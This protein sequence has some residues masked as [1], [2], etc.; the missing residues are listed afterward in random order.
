MKKPGLLAGI[1]IGAVLLLPVMAVSYL[2]TTLAGFTF[3][4]FALFDWIGR[5]LP[6]GLITS[7]IDSMVATVNAINPG[8][9]SDTYKQAEQIMALFMFVP[10]GALASSA[11]FAL[12][13]RLLRNRAPR[14]ALLPGILLGAVM[15]LVMLLIIAAI[16]PTRTTD[17]ITD[18]IWIAGLLVLWGVMVGYVQYRLAYAVDARNDA[19]AQAL[20]R[21]RFLV[22]VGGATAVVT[23]AGAGL[24][25]LLTRTPETTPAA[26]QTGLQP[27][28]EATAQ[29]VAEALPNANDPV[30]P[31]PGTRPEITPVD[32]HYRIDINLTPPAVDGD[33]WTLPFTSALG[34]AE[35]ATLKQYTLEEL[36]AFPV[37]EAYITMSCISN[38]IAGHLIDTLKWTGLNFQALLDDVGIPEGAT[39]VRI[40]AADDFDEVVDLETVRTDDRVILAYAWEDQPLTVEHGFPLRIHIPNRYGMKQP[41]WITEIEFLDSWQEGYWVRRGWSEDAFVRATAVVDT[42][43]IDAA[44]EQ[45]GQRMI[46]IGGIAWAGDRHLSTVQVRIDGGDWQPALIRAPISDRTWVIWRYDW[47]FSAGQHR[48]EVRCIEA[49]GTPQ[50]ES[51]ADVRPDGATGLHGVTEQF[52]QPA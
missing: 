10:V 15:A 26:P 38:P 20:D 13:P 1:L 3:L 42:V 5:V 6:G 11:F 16:P 50:I 23:V 33:T 2:G 22:Q 7:G 29:A 36:R 45:D 12:L 39:H 37:I 4:P 43:A 32:D 27:A 52:E 48:F 47:P 40:T 28:P 35:K 46:P 14:P 44:Y 34:G 9:T 24:G 30:I 31:A 19:S 21:R 25:S 18:S 17:A 49:D 51:R 41:K 8:A